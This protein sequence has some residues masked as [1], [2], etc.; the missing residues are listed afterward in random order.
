MPSSLLSRFL[1]NSFFIPPIP[2]I[3]ATVWWE[4]LRSVDDRRILLKLVQARTSLWYP[5]MT[6]AEEEN[7]KNQ[8]KKRHDAADNASDDSTIADSGFCRRKWSFGGRN[9]G[10]TWD[11]Q[12]NQLERAEGCNSARWAAVRYKSYPS[13]HT[14]SGSVSY[15]SLRL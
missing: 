10:H 3:P 6:M 9:T 12:R 4:R 2:K 15:A 8:E 13:E 7:S 5:A 1:I 14:S 11:D